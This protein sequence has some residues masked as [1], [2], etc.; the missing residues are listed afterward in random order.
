MFRDSVAC[1]R[2]V[3]SDDK[4]GVMR[5]VGKVVCWECGMLDLRDIWIWEY[6]MLMMWD[7]GDVGYPGCDMLGMCDVG[8]GAV[9]DVGRW[10]CGIS[11]C[12]MLGLRNVQDVGCWGCGMFRM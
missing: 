10:G 1:N 6:N 8:D 11:G 5:N 7:V 4:I 2:N 3:E 9:V 12:G